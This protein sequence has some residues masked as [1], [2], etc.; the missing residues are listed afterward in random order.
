MTT[1]AAASDERTQCPVCTS[2]CSTDCIRIPQVPIYC[3][4]LYASRDEALNAPTGDIDLCFCE[5][6]GQLFNRSFDPSRVD[7]SVEYENSLHYSARFR[8]YAQKLAQR[9]IDRYDLRHK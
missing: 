4:V 5:N 8:E 9:L 6:C 7:Y 1:S 3:N 2:L